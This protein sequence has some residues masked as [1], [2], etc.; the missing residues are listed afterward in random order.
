MPAVKPVGQSADKWARRA[1]QASQDYAKGV[2]APRRSWAQSTAA[3][4]DAWKQGVQEAAGRGAFGQGVQAAGDSKW[5]RK[6][7][8]VGAQRYAPGVNAAKGDYQ[9]G[10]AP[11]AA[12]IEGT[13]LP[14]RGPKGS[15]SNYQRTQA[16]GE[17]LHSAKV[18]SASQ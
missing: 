13:T 4:E 17:A 7:Q 9:S 11:Y 14:P 3:A 1:G 15:P 12:V 8:Q 6:S 10:F 18:G 16:I 5:S 2:Q